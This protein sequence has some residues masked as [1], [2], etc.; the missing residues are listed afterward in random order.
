MAE[1]GWPTNDPEFDQALVDA[2]AQGKANF[3]YKGRN[4]YIPPVAP[5]QYAP[6]M[7]FGAMGPPS[8]RPNPMMGGFVQSPEQGFVPGSDQIKRMNQGLPPTD[9]TVE[10][11]VTGADIPGTGQQRQ[12]FWPENDGGITVAAPPLE[13]LPPTLPSPVVLPGQVPQT[14]VM[15]NPGGE[16]QWPT[17]RIAPQGAGMQGGMPPGVAPTGAA[18]P[19][20]GVPGGPTGMLPPTLDRRLVDAPPATPEAQQERQSMWEQLFTRLQSHP[21]LW[22][23]LI[24]FGTD[25]MQPIQPGQNFAGHTG[26]ALQGSVDYVSMLQQ[27]RTQ[28]GL[29]QAQTRQATAAAGQ[30]EAVTE[31]RL[32]AEV[33]TETARAKQIDATT[34]KILAD[35]ED[36]KAL[37]GL[38]KEELQKRINLMQQQGILT[39]AQ[40]EE[41]SSKIKTPEERAA[42]I[43]LLKAHAAYYRQHGAAAGSTANFNM[44]RWKRIE[45]RHW[46][47]DDVQALVQQGKMDEAQALVTERTNKEWFAGGQKII[48]TEGEAENTIENFRGDWAA[49]LEANSPETKKFKTFSEYVE[50]RLLKADIPPAAK[51]AILARA[52]LEDKPPGNAATPVQRQGATP[53]AIPQRPTSVP[54]GS[55]YSASRKMWRDPQGN[56]YDEAGKPVGK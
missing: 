38:K 33:R 24:K 21:D 44:Y 53:Q 41:V 49:A 29:Q 10:Q 22:L 55:A 5:K 47:S 40:A 36:E 18:P 7:T 28:Q 52:K 50:W 4:Y 8:E 34:E 56:L 17:P 35:I 43:E 1:L 12:F 48:Q 23:S 19:G 26:R 13:M 32:P 11:N 30:T 54:A 27:M 42:A 2:M 45:D 25:M 14:P 3:N 51:S 37:F 46:Q 16:Y 20:G 9:V 15:P 6:A 31:Q 39:S